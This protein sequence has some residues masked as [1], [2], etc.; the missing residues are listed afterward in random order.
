MINALLSI[1]ELFFKKIVQNVC[2]NNLIHL[3]FFF[4]REGPKVMDV[5][6][7]HF[8]VSKCRLSPCFLSVNI[9]EDYKHKSPVCTVYT[10][11]FLITTNI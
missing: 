3:Y 11:F 8:T 9:L 4:H 6:G 5:T 7:V 10:H 1:Q 2:C